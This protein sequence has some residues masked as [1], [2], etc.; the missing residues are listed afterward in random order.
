MFHDEDVAY[1]TGLNRAGVACELH[2]Y[3]GCFHGSQS[4]V[5]DHPT[6]QRWVADEEAFLARA[7]A[8]EV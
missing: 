6:S 5:A 2:V 8:G 1:A 7:L 3:P 4:F